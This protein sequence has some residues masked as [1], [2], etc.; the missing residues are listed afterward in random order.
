MR[1]VLLFILGSILSISLSAQE[2]LTQADFGIQK[3]SVIG[4][5]KSWRGPEFIATSKEYWIWD[6]W[7]KAERK[8]HLIWDHTNEDWNPNRNVH[9]SYHSGHGKKTASFSHTWD[10][11]TARWWKTQRDTTIYLHSGKKQ[12]VYTHKLTMGSSFWKNH[13]KHVYTYTSD[14]SYSVFSYD[15]DPSSKNWQAYSRTDI[16]ENE[17]G[18]IDYFRNYSWNSLSK[19]WSFT[20]R[21]KYIYNEEGKMIEEIHYDEQDL[22]LTRSRSLY[23]EEGNL[24]ELIEDSSYPRGSEWSEAYRITFLYDQDGKLF[25]EDTEY[26][27]PTTNSWVLNG[28]SLIYGKTHS[29]ALLEEVESHSLI[30]NFPN[31][32]SPGT[33]FTCSEMLSGKKYTM[34]LIDLSGRLVDSQKIIGDEILSLKKWQVQGLY[35]LI[36]K[37]E[38]KLLAREKIFINKP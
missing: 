16:G 22:K 30:C 3:D 25:R 24:K 15:W 20:G 35:I 36:I 18:K 29:E 13:R 5:V 10:K 12:E 8:I 31:P 38:E 23:N 7:L 2:A 19:S 21:A 37:D 6:D 26:K 11:S 34:E 4:Y 27:D 14:R 33:P 1:K 9:F 28:Y 17:V 32:Y